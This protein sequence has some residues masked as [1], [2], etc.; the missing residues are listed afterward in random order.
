MQIPTILTY[1]GG[2]NNIKPL[3][4]NIF[5]WKPG[6]QFSLEIRKALEYFILL[7]F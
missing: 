7:F 5:L 2:F 6:D 4:A 3:I 1:P